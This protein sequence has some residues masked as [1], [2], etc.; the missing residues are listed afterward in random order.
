[1]T[2]MRQT[3]DDDGDGGWVEND[4]LVDETWEKRTQTKEGGKE[5]EIQGFDVVDPLVGVG[6]SA[7]GVPLASSSSV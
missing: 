2:G 4:G 5:M 6:A 7:A 1:M 3:V